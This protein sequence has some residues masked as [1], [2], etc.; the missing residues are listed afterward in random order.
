[1]YFSRLMSNDGLWFRPKYR[2]TSNFKKINLN[3]LYSFNQP[4]RPN[5][6]RIKQKL[7]TFYMYNVFL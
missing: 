1:M 2:I 5:S 7:A 3:S 4:P 6:N